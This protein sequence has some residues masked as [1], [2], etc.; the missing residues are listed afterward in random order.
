MKEL[1]ENIAILYVNLPSL[2]KKVM[3]KLFSSFFK[4]L[5]PVFLLFLTSVVPVKS[6]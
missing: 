3:K 5:A 1:L 4:E 2:L 6:N